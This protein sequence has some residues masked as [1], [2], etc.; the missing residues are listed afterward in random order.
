MWADGRAS[1]ENNYNRPALSI[2]LVRARVRVRELVSV[3]S[4]RRRR[5]A[6]RV[7]YESITRRR[8]RHGRGWGKHAARGRRAGR[9]TRMAAAESVHNRDA[10]AIRPCRDRNDAYED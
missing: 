1:Q 4:Q 6:V 9:R 3:R 10:L 8:R 2:R 5:G 7:I